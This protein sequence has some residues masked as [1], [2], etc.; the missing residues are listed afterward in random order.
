MRIVIDHIARIEGHAGFIGKIVNG[1]IKEAKI[2][3]R[4]GA[5]LFE[6]LL[7]GRHYF[8]APVITARICGVCPVIHNL[9]SINA[10]ENAFE[11][12]PH[13]LTVVLRQLM[14]AGQ[15]IQ[16][17]TLHLYFLVIADYFKT[18]SG[19]DFAQKYPK[20]AKAVLRLRDFGNKIIEAIGGRSIHPLTPEVGGF[21]KL[22]D[23]KKLEN[24]LSLVPENMSAAKKLLEIIALMPIP[25]FSRPTNYIA[26]YDKTGYFSYNG[27]MH[28]NI[29]SPIAPE[30]FVKIIRESETITTPSKRAKFHRKSYMVGALARINL[31]FEK[32]NVEAKNELE[33]TEAPIP[34]AN[35]FYN[36]IA[37]GIE[38]I[39]LIEEAKKL[40][41][42]YLSEMNN[43]SLNA[44]YKIKIGYG[45]AALEAPR[46]TLFHAYGID[47]NG[48][49]TSVNIITPT[50][51][52][53]N[54]L[55]EDLKVWLKN[56]PAGNSEEQKRQIMML[57]R[58]Y[59]PC[60]T[61]ATH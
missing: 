3:T 43:S 11:I 60:I 19:I 24:L 56:N 1:K 5:R 52:F 44:D 10:I 55:E 37:Q 57:I 59:D 17:H 8:D 7:V 61:C 14:L 26:M 47:K 39:H 15:V 33:K 4:E 27:L 13:P 20:D 50:V 29:N 49:I 40:L 28:S 12:K 48:L 32:L 53:L 16:S 31:N 30:K 25:N 45:V 21:T 18:A 36:N 46:G 22:P 51:Q 41:E 2:E 42:S 35:S 23:K 38:I 34:C 54:N 9:T 6:A 58:A